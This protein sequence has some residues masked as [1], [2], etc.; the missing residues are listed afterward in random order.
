MP[1]NAFISYTFADLA[2]VDSE[3]VPL[4]HSHGIETWHAQGE[5]RSAQRWEREILGALRSHEWFL[6]LM[7]EN[8][9][10]SEWVKNEVNWAMQNR[11]GKVIP[12]QLQPCA[13]EEFHLGIPRIEHVD[14]SAGVETARRKLL[15]TFGIEY[16]PNRLAQYH[17][18]ALAPTAVQPET[19]AQV[20]SQTVREPRMAF[21]CGQWVPPS[22]F[23]GRVNELNKAHQWISARQ[24][25]MVSGPPRS[26]KT[27]FLRRVIHDLNHHRQQRNL[28]SYVNLE[29][30]VQLNLRSFMEHTLL[31]IFGEMAR[32]VFSCRYSDLLSES[33]P[34]LPHLQEDRD[35][36]NFHRLFKLVSNYTH[37]DQAKRNQTFVIHEFVRFVNELLEICESKGFQSFTMFYDEANR[38]PQDISIELLNNL[39]EALSQTGLIG[40]YVVGPQMGQH[41]M[42]LPG[43][44]GNQIRIGPFQSDDEMRSLLIR[45][46]FGDGETSDQL[47]VTSSA[48]GYIWKASEG[49]PYLIQLLASGAFG[50]AARDKATEVD[51]RH[52]QRAYELVHTERPEAF[53]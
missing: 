51:A 28:S 24:N 50:E 17:A 5:M 52:V 31:C 34:S 35:F 25:F 30:G 12:V 46:Y 41:L 14:Y 16:D 3:L 45:Y 37:N 21:H 10:H 44:V 18:Q 26:G 27:S 15:A 32:K 2:F 8:S 13:S 47:P 19:K 9:I 4:L 6:L 39:G 43:L 53:Q 22:H 36:G 42:E 20:S 38:L 40:A 1:T 11:A 7:T 29:Q 33:G 48:Y 23:V 49:K